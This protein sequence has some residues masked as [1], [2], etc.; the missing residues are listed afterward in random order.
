MYSNDDYAGM[1]IGQ[2]EFYYG[3][4]VTKCLKHPNKSEEY[5]EE[6]EC[7]REWCF[8]VSLRDKSIWIISKSELKK[9]NPET[10]LYSPIQFLVA[11]V[12]TY[13]KEHKQTCSLHLIDERIANN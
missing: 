9:K 3:Y 13:F 8:E 7:E 12:E 5:C 2:L 10:S 11:G 1:T 4:E 6:K